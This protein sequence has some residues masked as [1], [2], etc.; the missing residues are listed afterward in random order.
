MDY[1]RENK[2][3]NALKITSQLVITFGILGALIL[4]AGDWT[5]TLCGA[6]GC[7]LSGLL[8]L[9]LAE[10]IFLLED[11]NRHIK[12]SCDTVVATLK[13]PEEKPT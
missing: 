6:L 5:L 9:G 12:K 13:E 2:I 11:I 7:G 8:I 10:I 4:G 3:A 1:Y